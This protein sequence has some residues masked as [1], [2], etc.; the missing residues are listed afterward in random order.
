MFT[1]IILLP[2]NIPQKDGRWMQ[3]RKIYAQSEY[4]PQP[5]SIWLAILSSQKAVKS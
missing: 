3:M 4:C 1:N 5:L 2:Q